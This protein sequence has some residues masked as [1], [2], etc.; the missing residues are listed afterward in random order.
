MLEICFAFLLRWSPYIPYIFLSCFTYFTVSLQYLPEIGCIGVNSLRVLYLMIC[1][2]YLYSRITNFAGYSILR[3]K[4]FSVKTLKTGHNC[5][6]T[7]SEAFE[8]SS[9]LLTANLWL[10]SFPFKAFLSCFLYPWCFE[11]SCDVLI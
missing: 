3:F 7:L 5:L 9:I 1:L 8:W 2:S 4:L 11:L 6:L 10:V